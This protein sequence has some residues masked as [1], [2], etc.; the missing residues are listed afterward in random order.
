MTSPTSVPDARRWNHNLH[1]SHLLLAHVGPRGGRVLDVGCGEGV[2]T[3]ALGRQ[4]SHVVGLDVDG[5]SLGLRPR[6]D[7]R[8]ERALRLRRRPR[9]S[10]P[11]GELRRGRVR[12]DAAPHVGGGRAA[13]HGRA[14][15]A[16]RPGRRAGAGA[17]SRLPHDLGREL[18]ATVS[19]RALK[20]R[21]REWQ[22]SAPVV[23]PPP[24]TYDEVRRLAAA[25]LSG[26][27]YKRLVLW[28][29]LVTWEKPHR[30]P[31]PYCPGLRS[32]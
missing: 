26:S 24:T 19:T 31:A 15:T 8:A 17:Q 13:G 10:V 16:R 6:A 22:H 12:G 25:T 14:R 30:G 29:Y 32:S 3:R 11:A 23:W 21:Q 2:L 27:S 18:A 4:S 7:G 28:R 20:L 5:P 1:Y 9:G